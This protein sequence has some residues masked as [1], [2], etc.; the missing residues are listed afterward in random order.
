M[1]FIYNINTEGAKHTVLANIP[2]P[3]PPPPPPPPS[4]PSDCSPWDI[5]PII[6]KP[7]VSLDDY[8]IIVS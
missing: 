2:T 5:C 1:L 4:Q 8:G 6:A 3:L 7:F